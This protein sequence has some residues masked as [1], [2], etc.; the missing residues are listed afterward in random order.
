MTDGLALPADTDL[1]APASL[2][3]VR[4]RAWMVATVG[5]AASG[6]GFALDSTQFYRSYLV[7]W[8]FWL[9]IALGCF[10][11]GLLH[12]LTRGA[13]GLMVR[14]ILGAATRTFPLLALLFIPIVLGMKELYLW[15]QPEVVAHDELIQQ[16]LWYLEPRFFIARA[17]FYFAV[18]IS[19]AWVLNR[20]S[21]RQDSERSHK[22]FRRM[23]FFAGPGLVLY[24][25]TA[26]FASVDWLMSLDPHWY[27]SIFG[28]SFIGGHAVSALA[29][30]IPVA[31]YFTRRPPLEGLLRPRHFHDYGKLLL[32]FVMLW[33]YFQLSQ[34]IIIW[35][36]NLPEEVKWYLARTEGGWK[37]IS[38]ALALGHF[39]LP[40]VLL[41]SRDLKRDA[42]RLASVALI[43]LAMRWL[44]LY[45]LAA[46]AFSHG[47]SHAG[48]SFHWLD[49]A[50][51]FAVGG[52]WTAFYTQQLQRRPMLP[53]FEPY[54]GEA[55]E[56]ED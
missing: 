1:S 27:S 51:V 24:A 41:L 21:L 16:K 18:W 54:L 12:Q 42:R 13:W 29:W 20:L 4:R 8:L 44:D 48:L 38:I 39:A 52:L 45:W 49:L 17:V 53:V 19:I 55:L 46:P 23:Q 50:T 15:A 6:L 33:T 25:L 30:L 34:L 32:A 37:W 31:L 56:D 43:L 47:D 22:L 40:F 7:A 5:I 26:T 3:G 10:A 14:R 11:L 36:G 2:D 9:G 28:I 35:S